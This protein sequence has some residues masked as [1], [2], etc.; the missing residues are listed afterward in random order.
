MYDQAWRRPTA[1]LCPHSR[2]H[3][4]LRN[5]TKKQINAVKSRKN[6]VIYAI[7]TIKGTARHAW[8]LTIWSKTFKLDDLVIA[9]YLVEDDQIVM[10]G[11]MAMYPA[12]TR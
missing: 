11:V 10:K 2:R 12:S 5:H 6:I 4:T 7:M 3:T 9:L 1:T 8:H